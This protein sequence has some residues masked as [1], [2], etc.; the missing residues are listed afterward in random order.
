M[1][2]KEQAHAAAVHLRECAP[3][4]SGTASVDVAPEILAAAFAVATNT[5]DT[6]PERVAD[7]RLYL[8]SEPTDSRLVASMMIKRIISDAIR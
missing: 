8:M 2:S 1:I 4:S 5:P 3:G 6:S 7:A